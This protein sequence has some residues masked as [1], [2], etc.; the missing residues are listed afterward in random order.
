MVSE[1]GIYI[2]AIVAQCFDICFRNQTIQH[3]YKFKSILSSIGNR[4]RVAELD[5]GLTLV[6]VPV[7]CVTL[8]V[9]LRTVDSCIDGFKELARS[10]DCN[11]AMFHED[12]CWGEG[13]MS[14]SGGKPT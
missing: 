1:F 11:G 2:A 7:D 12:R 4:L 5:E 13:S 10:C 8:A 9:F 6:W 3:L 14:L